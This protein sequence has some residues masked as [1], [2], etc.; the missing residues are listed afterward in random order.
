M[1]F[2]SK[3]AAAHLRSG[4]TPSAR[5]SPAVPSQL[6]SSARTRCSLQSNASLSQN[7]HER[8]TFRLS[9]S[10]H[11]K[12]EFSSSGRSIPELTHFHLTGLFRKR[13]SPNFRADG[14][15]LI[16]VPG[17]ACAETLV[18]GP[19][20]LSSGFWIVHVIVASAAALRPC[21]PQQSQVQLKT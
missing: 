15:T 20:T 11:F 21:R 16:Y 12:L 5:C 19:L 14:P 18:P 17:C 4:R 3:C 9:H 10:T 6:D 1:S 8:E 2:I 7:T 13:S